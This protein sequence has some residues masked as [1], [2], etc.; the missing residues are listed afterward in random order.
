MLLQDRF[1]A[2]IDW[3]TYE[4]IQA[5]LADNYA[6]YRDR[7]SR[8]VP[9]AG[10]TLLQGL[11]YCGQCG[12]KMMVG[13]GR[14]A[15]YVCRARTLQTG[16][17]ACQSAPVPPIDDAVARA[18]FEALAPAE[19]DLYEDAL[20]ARQNSL[21]GVDAAQE[22]E[23]KRLRYEADLARRR[24]DRA[25]PD[26]RN[27]ASEL[28]RR[29]EVA[30]SALRE[31]ERRFEE[32][33][34]D[35]GRVVPLHVPREL[36][37]AFAS[38]GQAMPALWA[39]STLTHANR[40]ALL[41]CIVDKV[42]LDRAAERRDFVHVRIVWK[43]GAASELDVAVPVESAA[44]LTNAAE[45]EGAIV[46]LARE[47]RRDD[48]VAELL[49]RQ[50]F[51]SARSTGVAVSWIATIRARHG[52]Q[53]PN[54]GREP[55]HVAGFLTVHEMAAAVGALPSWLYQGIRKKRVEIERDK[56]TGMYLFPDRPELIELLR[57]LHDRSDR[58]VRRVKVESIDKTRGY[59]HG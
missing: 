41:R 43:G 32:A 55:R 10:D 18:F 38:L 24:Y 31:A 29:W 14:S 54:P 5:L 42:V 3:A 25:D 39:G 13:S 58:E 59:Q 45:L 57:R 33:R 1:P 51:R 23:L 46:E 8:G 56:E 37:S 4:R 22:R 26:N 2:Y 28:E 49:T 48:E 44:D 12:R 20:Q 50:G 7:L 40:K 6:E 15:W 11:C 16:E 30:L 47:G 9:R 35:R 19:I 17:S 36:R 27:V 34:R 21:A 52:I 53:H